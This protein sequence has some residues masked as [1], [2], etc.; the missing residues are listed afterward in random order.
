MALHITQI[1]EKPLITE[2]NSLVGSAENVFVFQVH[3][4]ANKKM[5]K[6]AVEALFG[7]N[8]VGI[9]TQQKYGKE[10]RVGK[11]T[12]NRAQIKK[13]FVKLADGQNIDFF[14]A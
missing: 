7:V 11:Y 9:R 10:R 14:T 8:V 4:D 3:R 6:G 2:K 13:A 12:G 5:I 1:L